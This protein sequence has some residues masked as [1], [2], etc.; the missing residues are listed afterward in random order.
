[1]M[2]RLPILSASRIW[3]RVLLILCAPVCARSSLLNHTSA[4]PHLRVSR[5]ANIRGVGRPTRSRERASSSSTNS[6]SY[7]PP[8]GP[9]YPFSTSCRTHEPP[10]LLAVFLAR[11]LF[12]RARGVYPVGLEE[13]YRLPYVLRRQSPG[14][15]DVITP[16]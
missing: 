10:N 9:K 11:T 13:P 16:L 6:G 15:E 2:R 4:P 12:Q 7:L 1:M 8:K 3:P 14:D 5:S